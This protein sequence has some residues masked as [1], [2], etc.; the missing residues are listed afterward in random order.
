[1]ADNSEYLLRQ[2]LNAIISQRGGMSV[3]SGQ[4]SSFSTA[5]QDKLQEYRNK[6]EETN[7]RREKL[8]LIQ[9]ELADR[10]KLRGET[11]EYVKVLKEAKKQLGHEFGGGGFDMQEFRNTLS[12]FEGIAHSFANAVNTYIEFTTRI[13]TMQLDAIKTGWENISQGQ[14]PYMSKS[15]SIM[16]N[17]A[18]EMLEA[19][20]E[21]T[22]ATMGLIGTISSVIGTAGVM[23]LMTG[24]VEIGIPAMAISGVM[25]VV[26][27]LMESSAKLIE[28]KLKEE[29][30]GVAKTTESIGLVSGMYSD[31]MGTR[32]KIGTYLSTSQGM[33]FGDYTNRET[34]VQGLLMDL[35]RKYGG[36]EGMQMQD[37]LPILQM[38]GMSKQFGGVGD[39]KM[40]GFL[41]NTQTLSKMTGL[42][43]Q[44]IMQTM[45][46]MR[47]RLGTPIDQLQDKFMGL[48]NVSEKLALPLKQVMSDFMELSKANNK[49]GYSQEQIMGL[50][51]SFG[52][53]LKKGTVTVADLS[54]YMKGMMETPFEKMIGT[55]QLLSSNPDMV[56]K[57]YQGNAGVAQ[58]IL[59][60]LGGLSS[61]E[62]ALFGQIMQNPETEFES[63][64]NA[65]A[66]MNKMGLSKQDL[67]SMKPE[68]S[69]MVRNLGYNFGSQSEDL[70][71][72]DFMAT[73]MMH[74]MGLDL[75]TDLTG[76]SRME[77]G[78]M[79]TGTSSNVME[80]LSNVKNTFSSFS[81]E[82]KSEVNPSIVKE[83]ELKK[84]LV[85]ETSKFNSEFLKTGKTFDDWMLSLR[86]IVPET[87]DIINKHVLDI[88]ANMEPFLND[89]GIKSSALYTENDVKTL[90]DK[91]KDN[92]TSK[93]T[94]EGDYFTKGGIEN[95]SIRK[96]VYVDG[97]PMSEETV[98]NLFDKAG[99]HYSK[100]LIEKFE[101]YISQNR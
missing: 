82:L 87:L 86:K 43:S 78:I 83:L 38:A 23:G 89:R 56:L 24:N 85:M 16:D 47:I 96:D 67:V 13:Q 50:Y 37:F 17:Y 73:Q 51:T 53:E 93:N 59:G 11:E 32:Q 3:G 35:E 49:Y 68:L 64:P 62:R 27:S 8:L 15:L 99:I 57:N 63:S 10:E 69:K 28:A 90:A 97:K 30:A 34:N 42:G 61:G 19:G 75:P 66:L 12:E 88:K 95:M 46:E 91:F 74:S 94:L 5:S 1:M 55:M 2:I 22:Q 79:N 41:E 31:V 6:A 71:M 4:P 48:I 100:G 44:D 36:V 39:N 72:G 45:T 54:H 9:S 14:T 60:K 52:D 101:Q 77:K 84:Q 25:Q 33:G 80:G 65:K 18:K 21:S 92:I 81:N 29:L 76:R 20:K 7:N 70:G 26:T 58:D 98:Q 40:G